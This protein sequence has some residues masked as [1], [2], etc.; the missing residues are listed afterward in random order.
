MP[1]TPRH[2]AWAAVCLAGAMALAAALAEPR[3][4]AQ[5][6][7]A[8]IAGAGDLLLHIKV[9]KAAARH[10]W[11]RVFE[12][13]RATRAAL[14]PGALMVANLETPL[15]REVVPIRTGSPPILGAPP[16]AA[17][18]LREAGLDA[19][20]CANNHA[21]DQRSEGLAR[22]LRAVTAAGLAP[23]GAGE[24]AASAWR[25]HVVTRG[26]LRVAFL[27]MTD[28]LNRAA[29]PAPPAVVAESEDHARRDAAIR[30]ARAAADVVVL[31][32]HWSHDFAAGPTRLQ[33]RRARRWVDLGVDLVL[34]SGP[35]VLH[36]V[37]RIESPRGEAVI[38]Y[39]LG[40]LVSNQGQ[41]YRPGVR[42]SPAAHPAVRLAT[43][44]DGAFLRTVFARRGDRLV[45]EALEALP[46]WTE[47]D[48]WAWHENPR[49]GHDIRMV[50]LGA[51]SDAVQAARRP[52]IARALGPAVRL[53]WPSTENM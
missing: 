14:G 34:G 21:F 22:T 30:A 51:A 6:P 35:H 4:A 48:F 18:A 52:A 31:F 46:L 10:G 27:S 37:E 42:M 16:E 26:G 11:P 5:V 17:A 7:R 8:E 2:L 24:S 13:V 36:P 45:V 1:R 49:Q 53:R 43:T 47:N 44:R 12:G 38:A 28:H 9:L 50:P 33:R 3:A 39:S 25:P 32:V 40:N 41:R 19:L 15:T 29:G 20:A 23:L